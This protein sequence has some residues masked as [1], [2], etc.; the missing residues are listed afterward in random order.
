MPA[1]Y[2]L[3]PI[4]IGDDI[5]SRTITLERKE[6]DA[7]VSLAGATVTFELLRGG[8]KI[9]H[10]SDNAGNGGISVS[11]EAAG[12]I[13][14]AKIST[15]GFTAA[16]YTYVLRVEYADSLIVTFVGGKQPII[17]K[18]VDKYLGKRL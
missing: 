6:N 18:D 17:S 8:T 4:V 10:T 14:I 9:Y 2:D 7:V 12:I 13:N 11:D 1:V 15:S 5:P 3:V 16:T